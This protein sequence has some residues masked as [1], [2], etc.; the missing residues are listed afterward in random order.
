MSFV[1]R[2][3]FPYT[4]KYFDSSDN[5][6]QQLTDYL[7]HEYLEIETYTMYGSFSLQD[8][9]EIKEALDAS[10]LVNATIVVGE[11]IDTENPDMSSRS[12]TYTKL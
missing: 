3:T 5:E 10:P 8:A 11:T 6:K 7:M 4:D 2:T 1:V 12:I 9:I